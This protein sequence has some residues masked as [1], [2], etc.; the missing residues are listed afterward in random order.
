MPG[1]PG[2]GDSLLGVAVLVVIAKG[3]RRSVVAVKIGARLHVVAA[4]IDLP[5]WQELVA[6]LTGCRTDLAGAIAPPAEILIERGDAAGSEVVGRDAPHKS[7]GLCAETR[8]SVASVVRT[9]FEAHAAAG[10]LRRVGGD[11]ADHP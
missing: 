4:Q 8:R 5:T 6:Q 3:T 10:S 7:V 11:D 2:V 1:E 9:A